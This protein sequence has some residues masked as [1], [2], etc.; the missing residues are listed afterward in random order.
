MSATAIFNREGTMHELSILVEVV[1]IVE[2]QAVRLNVDSVK[3]IVLQVGELSSVVPEFMEEYFPNVVDGN[4]M[5]IDTVLKIETIPGIARCKECRKAFNVVEYR[6]YC[7]KCGS[8]DKEMLCGQEFFIK[9][10]LVP[11]G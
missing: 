6:G 9:E 11:E 4:P 7:P 3:A 5:F 2:E 8:F 10:I 1:R